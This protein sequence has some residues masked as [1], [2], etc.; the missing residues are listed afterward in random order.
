VSNRRAINVDKLT[1]VLARDMTSPAVRNQ[2][3]RRVR[4]CCG[5]RQGFP[6]F[7][8]C[9]KLVPAVQLTASEAMARAAQEAARSFAM[10]QPSAIVTP[11]LAD[12]LRELYGDLPDRFRVTGAAGGASDGAE[13]RLCR[14]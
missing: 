4:A 7:A 5:S 8:D 2:P 12:E 13:G 1:R 6:H 14:S 9:V 3:D 11:A 10:P